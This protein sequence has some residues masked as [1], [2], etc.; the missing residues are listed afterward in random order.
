LK[1]YARKAQRPEPSP[2]GANFWG[3]GSKTARGNG[4]RQRL[5]A[6]EEE[7]PGEAKLGEPLGPH[8][9]APWSFECEAETGTHVP[10]FRARDDA[11]NLQPTDQAWNVQGMAN[12]MAQRITVVVGER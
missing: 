6:R 1:T 3:R 11:G 12:N 7:A 9:W 2:S 4:S 10:Y 5:A 8:A